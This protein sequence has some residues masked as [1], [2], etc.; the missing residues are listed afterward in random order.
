[1][2]SKSGFTLVELLVVIA[3]IGVLISLLLPAVQAAREASRRMSCSNKLRQLGLGAHN[4]HDT[5]NSLPGYDFGPN[6]RDPYESDSQKYSTFVALL[7]FI[8]LQPL[9]DKLKAKDDAGEMIALWAE[10]EIWSTPVPALHCPSDSGSSSRGTWNNSVPTS[11]SISSGDI[12]FNQYNN[13]EDK[14]YDRIGVGRGPFKVGKWNGFQNITDGTSNTVMM[15]ERR[16][17]IDGSRH[18]LAGTAYSLN[19]ESEFDPT[20]GFQPSGCLALEGEGRQYVASVTS[21]NIS[22]DSGLNWAWAA[23]FSTSFSTI[24]PP[25]SPSCSTTTYQFL[26]SPSSYH[27]GGAMVLYCDGSVRFTSDMIEPGNLSDPPVKSGASPY[28]LW[29]ALGSASGGESVSNL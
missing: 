7:P 21:E 28:G 18:V 25:N 12:P 16:I 1:M 26:G 29:G 3:I 10:D 24:L 23:P 2:H 20:T 9:F 19:L 4:Y 14:T 27:S 17:S 15:S 11:Y 6:N 13:P 5:Y 8:E 22:N